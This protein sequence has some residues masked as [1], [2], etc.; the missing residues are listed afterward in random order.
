MYH[1]VE[2]D[3][4]DKIALLGCAHW[5]VIKRI[6]KP[7]DYLLHH[8]RYSAFKHLFKPALKTCEA[9]RL[10]GTKKCARR[11]KRFGKIAVLPGIDFANILQVLKKKCLDESRLDMSPCQSLIHLRYFGAGERS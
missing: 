3:G 11:S 5:P 1:K 6:G 8:A 2:G 7:G 4:T 10:V 9:I